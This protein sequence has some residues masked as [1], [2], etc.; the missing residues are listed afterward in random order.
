LYQ[1]MWQIHEF[2]VIM[3]GF[4]AHHLQGN[5]LSLPHIS[6]SDHTTAGSNPAGDFLMCCQCSVLHLFYWLELMSL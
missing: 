2:P 1:D 3:A 6:A 5:S 4:I